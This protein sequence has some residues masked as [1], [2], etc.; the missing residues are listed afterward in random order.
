MQYGQIPGI[1]KPVSRL[2][3]GT[4]MIGSGDLEGSFSLL[5]SVFETGCNTFDT[6]HIYGGGD[7]E[8]TFGRWVRDRGIH[9]RVVIVAKGAHHN[10]DRRRVT[11]WDITADIYDSLARF[12]TDYMDLY[13]LHRDDPDFPVGPIVDIL[14][15]HMQAGRIHAF[16]GSNWSHT[17]IAQANSYA[18][19]NGL[20]GF[21]LSNPH[22]SLARQKE[23]PWPECVT[24]TGPEAA[25]ARSYYQETQ[26]PLFV[27]SSVAAGF[28]S[29]RFTRDNLDSFQDGYDLMSIQCYA[30]EDNFQ[31][32]DRAQE[33]AAEKGVS[34]NQIALAWVLG[35]SFN[36]FPLVGA[37]KAEEARQNA[38]ALNLKLTA[39]ELAWLNLEADTR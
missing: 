23:E 25:E 8:R 36:V 17:R 16:G 19:A 31:R 14:N 30:T 5:D 39:G 24:I 33:L 9:D 18:K 6:A 20:T 13:I 10:A 4:V 32:L 12:K 2:V 11:P 21:A 29:G 22:F 26:M 7:N 28:F 37:R 1:E 3:Q 35:Q 38:E 27:W 15:E 34:S